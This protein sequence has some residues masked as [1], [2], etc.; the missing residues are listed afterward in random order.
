MATFSEELASYIKQAQENGIYN[1][2]DPNGG[3]N[4]WSLGNFG[5]SG[6]VYGDGR[7]RLH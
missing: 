3:G 7:Y 2:F 4:T 6:G 1:Y 5:N